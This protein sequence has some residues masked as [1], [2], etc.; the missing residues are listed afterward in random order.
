MMLLRKDSIDDMKCNVYIFG[1]N[2][3]IISQI[4]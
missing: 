1:S 3:A 4:P 2:Q